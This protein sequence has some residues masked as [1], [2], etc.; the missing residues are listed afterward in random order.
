ML[1]L[2]EDVLTKSYQRSSTNSRAPQSAIN[3]IPGINTRTMMGGIIETI[4]AQQMVDGSAPTWEENPAMAQIDQLYRERVFLS[5]CGI[6]DEGIGLIKQ[7]I[8]TPI[9][10]VWRNEFNIGISP[11][12]RK[13]RRFLSE[14]I[15]SGFFSEQE[16]LMFCDGNVSE[17]IRD[18]T[19]LALA[20]PQIYSRIYR[21]ISSSPRLE[22][23]VRDPESVRALAC[24]SNSVVLRMDYNDGFDYHILHLSGSIDLFGLIIKHTDYFNT[25]LKI[26]NTLFAD[27]GHY[28]PKELVHM[29]NV[30]QAIREG[31][32]EIIIV[33]IKALNSGKTEESLHES[34]KRN[35]RYDPLHYTLTLLHS[36][37]KLFPN[38]FKDPCT[39]DALMNSIKYYLLKLQVHP[40]QVFINFREGDLPRL[41]QP[42]IIPIN[43]ITKEATINYLINRLTS[44]RKKR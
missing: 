34:I 13:N 1:I 23:L 4:I 36:F 7:A 40:L 31:V 14:L 20:S 43:N 37:K 2:H 21:K 16:L 5:L 17:W 9:F 24:L 10:T 18:F 27:R 35:H 12:D 33:E 32:A 41:P 44:N 15:R 28:K 29:R 19:G 30:L 22:G 26:P 39:M 38:E 6:A 25:A 3:S 11:A 42:E 8:G